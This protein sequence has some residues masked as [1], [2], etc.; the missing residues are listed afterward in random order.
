[1]FAS[2]GTAIVSAFDGHEMYIKNEYNALVVAIDDRAAAV[3]ALKR[4]CH[5]SS[6]RKRLIAGAHETCQQFSWDKSDQVFEEGLERLY[7]LDPSPIGIGINETALSREFTKWR[8]INSV[9]FRL[10]MLLAFLKRIKG[11][12]I[13]KALSS[14]R[15]ALLTR[16]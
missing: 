2:G 10:L 16:R 1:M 13:S 15:S 9:S 6:L 11:V 4:L 5:D 7:S 12:R 14:F 3:A 8:I